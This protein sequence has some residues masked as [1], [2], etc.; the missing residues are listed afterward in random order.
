MKKFSSASRERIEILQNV[1]DYVAG[2][3][4]SIQVLLSENGDTGFQMRF[5]NYCF[6]SMQQFIKP[7]EAGTVDEHTI[8]Y[9][10]VFMVGGCLALMHE[11][12]KNGMDIPVPEMAKIMAK[13]VRDVPA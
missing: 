3:S 6:K 11:W 1:F 2:N 7:K 8:K 4:N 13:L 10:S 12:L 5:F 9:A